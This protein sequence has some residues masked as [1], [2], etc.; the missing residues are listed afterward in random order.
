MLARTTQSFLGTGLNRY[1]AALSGGEFVLFAAAAAPA[2]SPGLVAGRHIAVRDTEGLANGDNAADGGSAPR[3][4]IFGYTNLADGGSGWIDVNVDGSVELEEVS[5][6]MRVGLIR[7]RTDDVTLTAAGSI[8]DADPADPGT[9]ATDLRDV[10]GVNIDLVATAGSIGTEADFVETNLLDSVGGTAQ[11]GTVDAD[12]LLA[13]L[14][15]ETAGDLRVGLVTA[16]QNDPSKTSDATLATRAGSILDGDLDAEADVVAIRIDLAAAGGGI[17]RYGHDLGIDSSVAGWKS[18]SLYAEATGNIQI[19]ETDDELVVLAAKSRDGLVRLTVPDTAA[20]RGP[21]ATNPSEDAQPQDLILLAT[22]RS[23]VAQNDPRNVAPST[24]AASQAATGTR[25]GI[26]ASHGHRPVGRR[27]RQRAGHDRDRRGRH[28]HDPRRHEPPVHARSERS[29]EP[30]QGQRRA[31]R[32]QRRHRR[33]PG[34]WGTTMLFGGRV[35]GVFDLGGASDPTD[36]TKIF[37][38]VDVDTFTF[39]QTFLGAK[40]RVYGSQDESALDE[41]DG[42]DRFVVDRLQTMA[43]AAGHTLTLDGQARSDSYTILTTGSQ[44]AER[45]YVVNVLDTGAQDDGVDE[46]AI[47]GADGTLNGESSPGVKYPTDDIFL[48][49]RVTQIAGETGRPAGVRRAAA[50]HAS[51]ACATRSRATRRHPTPSA[52]TTTPPST[53]A[54]RSS[55]SAATTSSPPTTTARSRR[56]TAAPATTRSRSAR[57]SARSATSPPAGWRRRTSSRP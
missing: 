16:R 47:F 46:L 41:A 14:I 3:I 39:D 36:L 53:G 8:L 35:G 38:H 2:E 17:G 23:L 52:S 20:P 51:T 24:S 43:V 50:R 30:R 33:G 21:P 1:A 13:V 44:G 4:R 40:T 25:S 27:R 31:G 9:S 34:G 49:R 28:D 22:G 18:G 57:S 56:S 12:A 54:C 32:R 48:L 6:D 29:I 11:T 26:W 10:E 37:G 5:G 15:Y 45:N 7:S 19:T 55:A 42:E